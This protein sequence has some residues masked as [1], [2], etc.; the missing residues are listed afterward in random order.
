MEAG[1]CTLC[2]PALPPPPGPHW[3]WGG[4]Q[5]DSGPRRALLSPL[6]PHLLAVHARP[7]WVPGPAPHVSSSQREAWGQPRRRGSLGSR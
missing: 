4:G 2:P 7:L 6:F 3:G 5:V 1:L